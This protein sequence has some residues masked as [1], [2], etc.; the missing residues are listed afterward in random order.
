V[1]NRRIG[2]VNYGMDEHVLP[3]PRVKRVQDLAPDGPVGLLKSGC[4]IASV[5]TQLMAGDRLLW[6][7]GMPFNPTSRQRK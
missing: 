7:I 2:L 4:I 1:E 5:H 3:E 6:S